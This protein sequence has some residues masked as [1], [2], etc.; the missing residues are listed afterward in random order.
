MASVGICGSDLKYWKYG[1]C[2]R[3]TLVDPMIIGHEGSGTVVKVGGAVKD[4]NPGT[5]F[6]CQLLISK[7]N[8]YTLM[9]ADTISG[10]N[11]FLLSLESYIH[12]KMCTL[13]FPAKLYLF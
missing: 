9:V 11:L 1:V 13:H 2:G 8:V 10:L 3:F 6:H 5:V 12:F 4:L 7:K